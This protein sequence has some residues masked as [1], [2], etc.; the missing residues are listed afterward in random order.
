MKT[1]T[2]VSAMIL[3]MCCLMMLSGCWALNS[4]AVAMSHAL[5]LDSIILF[6][7]GEPL[8]ACVDMP[9]EGCNNG[10]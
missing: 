1:R 7:A 3:A 10:A 5:G 8:E 2:R 4:P 9:N 6:P